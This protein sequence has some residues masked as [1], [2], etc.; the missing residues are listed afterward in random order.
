M[1]YKEQKYYKVDNGSHG[2]LIRSGH[3]LKKIGVKFR[4]I[5][6]DGFSY[7]S[8]LWTTINKPQYKK[9][10]NQINNNER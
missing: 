2:S 7:D 9:Y 3:H 8:N 6:E 1:I 5:R 4:V 10:I